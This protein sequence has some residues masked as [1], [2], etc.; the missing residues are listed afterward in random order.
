MEKL[1]TVSE[2][3]SLL[4][5][6]KISVYGLV[7]RKKIPYIKVSGRMLRF[8]RSEIV[9]WLENKSHGVCGSSTKLRNID[10]RP[11]QSLKR[12]KTVSTDYVSRLVARARTDVLGT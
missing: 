12:K 11:K 6:K 4:S 1:L 7:N 9:A 8:D 2:V 3:A 5:I 10:I